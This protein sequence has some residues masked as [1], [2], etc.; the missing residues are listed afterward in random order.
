MYVPQGVLNQEGL[1]RDVD[2]VCAPGGRCCPVA[3]SELKKKLARIFPPHNIITITAFAA[4]LPFSP[5]HSAHL[6]LQLTIF[7]RTPSHDETS[8]GDQ[9]AAQGRRHCY[10]SL[11]QRT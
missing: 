8:A 9:R 10:C 6:K 1:L 2:T 3:K 7:F 4:M 11:Q 5:M